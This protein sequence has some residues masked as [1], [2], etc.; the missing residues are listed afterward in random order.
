MTKLV[1]VKGRFYDGE[2]VWSKILVEHNEATDKVYIQA[3]AGKNPYPQMVIGALKHLGLWELGKELNRGRANPCRITYRQ[4]MSGARDYYIEFAE[5]IYSKLNE[6]TYYHIVRKFVLHLSMNDKISEAFGWLGD[7]VLA[8]N[9]IKDTV[10]V[11]V[12]KVTS[13]PLNDEHDIFHNLEFKKPEELFT[14]EEEEPTNEDD[15]DE[16]IEY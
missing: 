5:P 9:E 3:I 15:T 1:Y 10:K 12:V 2:A 16:D 8:L 4:G 6:Q 7:I 13:V 14:E 11:K